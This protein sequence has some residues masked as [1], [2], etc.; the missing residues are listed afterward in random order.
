MQRLHAVRNQPDMRR[1]G[2]VRQR[3]PLR[4]ERQSVARSADELMAKLEVVKEALGCFVVGC[5]D[6]P[7]AVPVRGQ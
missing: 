4:K 5:D 1:R 2:L 6:D 3:F 7:G